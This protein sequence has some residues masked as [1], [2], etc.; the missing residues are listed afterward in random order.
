MCNLHFNRVEKQKCGKKFKK[1][2]K[3]KKP[4][5]YTRKEWEKSYVR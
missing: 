2:K 3:G 4:Y 5:V 1:Y